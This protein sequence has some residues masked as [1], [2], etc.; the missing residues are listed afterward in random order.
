MIRALFT[1][2]TGISSHGDVVGQ[3]APTP[4]GSGPNHAFLLSRSGTF[5]T[6]D[7]PGALSSAAVGMNSRGDILGEYSNSDGIP[8]TYVMNADP[9]SPGGQFKAIADAPGDTGSVPIGIRGDD[10]VGAYYVTNDGFSAGG[11]DVHQN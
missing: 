8:H 1:A 4:D 11:R 5:S 7:F 10:I 3:Y 9:F 2:A 6:V